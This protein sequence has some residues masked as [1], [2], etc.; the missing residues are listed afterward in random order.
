[1]AECLHYT[2]TVDPDVALLGMSFPNEQDD[3]FVAALS[4][5]PLNART[6]EDIRRRA[7]RAIEGKGACWWNP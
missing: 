4:F 5:A 3:S 1:M 2:L 6:M 7:A